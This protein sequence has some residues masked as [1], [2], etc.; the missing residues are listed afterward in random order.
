M[1]KSREPTDKL[2]EKQKRFADYY[3][4]IA[5]AEQAAVKA[6]YSAKYA[7]GNAHKLVANSCIKKYI[8]ERLAE[9]ESKRVANAQEVM[10]YLTSVMRGEHTEEVVV[11]EAT[12]DGFSSARTIDKEISAKDRLKAAELLGKR[13][14]LFTDKMDVSG[15]LGVNIIDDL[16]DG[17][18]DD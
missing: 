15:S 13:Y 1:P 6:G 10:E 9:L 5:N 11:V 2:T 14:A 7:R 16:D 12:G 18:G 17:D 8:D 3:I 4:E